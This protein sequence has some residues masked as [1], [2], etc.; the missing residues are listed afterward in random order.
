MTKK[1]LTGYADQA[2]QLMNTEVEEIYEEEQEADA[3]FS[4]KNGYSLQYAPYMPKAHI[5]S[6]FDG[7]VIKEIHSTTSMNKMLEAIKEGVA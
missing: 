4:L 2:A 3:G 7:K 5:L 1:V 6:H